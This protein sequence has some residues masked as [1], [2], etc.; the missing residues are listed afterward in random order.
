MA[1]FDK[2]RFIEACRA[3]LAEKDAPAAI[4]ELVASAVREP[5]H[6]LSALGG[7]AHPG[8]DVLYRAPDLTILDLRCGPQM[9]IKPHDHRMWAVIGVYCGREENAFFR[10]ADRGLERDGSRTLAAGE[11]ML[12]GPEVIHAVANP[13]DRITGALHVYGGDLVAAR[14]SEWDPQTFE[15]Q[16]YCVEDTLRAMERGTSFR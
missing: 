9:D 4:R 12:L 5:S 11:T 7:A 14:R 10:R 16:P 2:A 6:V 1:A 15:E 3:A 13:F 8:V